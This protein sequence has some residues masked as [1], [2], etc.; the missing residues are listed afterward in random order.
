MPDPT[1]IKLQDIPQNLTDEEILEALQEK[2]GAVA[3]V[4]VPIDTGSRIPKNRGFAIANFK[5]EDTAKA[6]I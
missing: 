6:A 3:R 1:G 2:F 5:T 4:W